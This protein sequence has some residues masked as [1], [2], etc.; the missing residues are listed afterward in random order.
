MSRNSQWSIGKCRFLSH[1]RIRRNSLNTPLAQKLQPTVEILCG[2]LE[3]GTHF[4]TH[5]CKS[6]RRKV[7]GRVRGSV[8]TLSKSWS[9]AELNRFPPSDICDSLRH[10][11][12]FLLRAHTPER[13]RR[14]PTNSKVNRQHQRQ[15]PRNSATIQTKDSMDRPEDCFHCRDLNMEFNEVR[16]QQRALEDLV[17]SMENRMEDQIRSLENRLEEQVKILHDKYRAEMNLFLHRVHSLHEQFSALHNKCAHAEERL[18]TLK[19]DQPQ[20]R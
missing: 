15:K 9:A 2:Y 1:L 18:E 3:R 19:R 17:R 13:L 20:E 11:K 14:I 6:D 10:S 8:S 7:V 12:R 4:A 5:L 16:A